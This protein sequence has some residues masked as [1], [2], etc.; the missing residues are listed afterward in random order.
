MHFSLSLIHRK[1]CL[2]YRCT[3][4]LRGR[5]PRT[6]LKD[7]KMGNSNVRSFLQCSTQAHEPHKAAISPLVGPGDVTEPCM[8]SPSWMRQKQLPAEASCDTVCDG[9]GST[10]RGFVRLFSPQPSLCVVNHRDKS[11]ESSKLRQ[12]LAQRIHGVTS[13]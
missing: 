4:E 1:S 10:F 3:S 6:N 5:Y 2:S 9:D 7:A 12:R 13:S 11:A 8:F